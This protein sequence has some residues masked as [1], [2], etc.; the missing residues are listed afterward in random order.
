MI[1]MIMAMLMMM[2][3]CGYH[4]DQYPTQREWDARLMME[5]SRAIKS[6]SIHYHLAGT[7]KVTPD[8]SQR[9]LGSR[10]RSSHSDW[11]AGAAGA[12]QAGPGGEVPGRLRADRR[13]PSHLHR[14]LLSRLCRFRDITTMT[15]LITLL[16]QDEIGDK[17][18]AKALACPD[19]FVLKPQREGGGNNVYG[20]DIKPF[21][22]KIR[23]S[24]ERNAY[25]LMDRIH[26]P[27]TKASI[28]SAAMLVMSVSSQNYMVRPHAEPQLVDV[29]SELGIFGYVIGDAEKIVTNKQVRHVTRD[30]WQLR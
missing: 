15:L 22:E 8:Q 27:V 1:L 10:G 24:E 17:N 19:K 5:R 12:G 18:F 16:F 29:I 21:L 2:L 13:R 14:T 23:H 30:T 26:P 9:G 7:K 3:R 20:E 6:P 11:L 4:P 28:S 25:I